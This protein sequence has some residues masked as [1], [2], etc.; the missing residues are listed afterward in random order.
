M[1]SL[2]KTKEGLQAG[3]NHV[4]NLFFDGKDSQV[5][6]VKD[7]ASKGLEIGEDLTHKSADKI[8]DLFFKGG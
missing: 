5:I 6:D 3:Q 8:K 2:D 1:N 4:K 7:L